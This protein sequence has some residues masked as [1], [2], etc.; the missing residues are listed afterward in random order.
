MQSL[1]PLFKRPNPKGGPELRVRGV[2][3]RQFTRLLSK[4]RLSWFKR[5]S[6]FLVLMCF[7]QVMVSIVYGWRSVPKTL[8]GC[9]IG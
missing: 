1:S 8:V 4:T 2:L 3:L 6:A 5:M 9:A 7:G